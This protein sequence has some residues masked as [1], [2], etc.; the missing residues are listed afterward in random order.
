MMEI[1]GKSILVPVSE[2]SSYRESTVGFFGSNYTRV[3]LVD[4][5]AFKYSND[6][7]SSSVHCHFTP[8]QVGSQRGLM[9]LEQNAA[10]LRRLLTSDT[11]I[12]GATF[13]RASTFLGSGDFREDKEKHSGN[14]KLTLREV[15]CQTTV[16]ELTEHLSHMSVIIVFVCSPNVDVVPDILDT[17]YAMDCIPTFFW[18]IAAHER[19]KLRCL[20]WNSPCVENLLSGLKSGRNGIWWF[21]W[22]K[23]ILQKTLQLFRSDTVIDDDGYDVALPDEGFV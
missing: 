16:L 20:Y 17:G 11:L 10:Q 13:W 7:C 4:I 3:V 15:Y 2:G 5:A 14:S 23:S 22:F 9:N 8:S 21:S 6:D 19:P 18:K 1:Q 12:N